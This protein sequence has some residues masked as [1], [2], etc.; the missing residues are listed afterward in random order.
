MKRIEQLKDI[1]SISLVNYGVNNIAFN[2]QDI[3]KVLNILKRLNIAV[4]GGDI[5]IMRNGELHLTYDNWFCDQLE[6]EMYLMYVE[7]SIEKTQTYIDNYPLDDHA[8][9]EI[10]I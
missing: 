8:Y 1:K 10:V 9:V 6:N 5:W 2:I 7:R 3:K 4:K